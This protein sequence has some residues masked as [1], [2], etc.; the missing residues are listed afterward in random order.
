MCA[1]I[2]GKAGIYFNVFPDALAR[3]WSIL[4][5]GPFDPF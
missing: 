1:N 4:Y 2:C 3:I 5:Y